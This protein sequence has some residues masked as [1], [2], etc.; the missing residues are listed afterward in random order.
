MNLIQELLSLNESK[1]T[2][3]QVKIASARDTG[4]YSGDRVR[5]GSWEEIEFDHIS[6]LQELADE[7]ADDGRD[8]KK[9]F[10]AL[11]ELHAYLEEYHVG[12]H[13]LNNEVFDVADE[14]Y[15]VKS[16]KD[17]VLKIT[18]QFTARYNKKNKDSVTHRGE[19]TLMDEN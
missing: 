18:Y 12:T 8:G 15:D 7:I 2:K 5:G 6:S 1:G 11:P 9:I 14:S 10:K 16:F 3:F 17:D 13:S 19:I 4:D